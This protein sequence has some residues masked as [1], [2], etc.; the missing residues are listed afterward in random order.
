[1]RVWSKVNHPYPQKGMIRMGSTKEIEVQASN[2]KSYTGK[3]TLITNQGPEIK[4]N[5]NFKGQ[6]ATSSISD[7]D[8]QKIFPVH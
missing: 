8:P 6:K 7:Q 5:T 2:P 3:K 1:M 4:A